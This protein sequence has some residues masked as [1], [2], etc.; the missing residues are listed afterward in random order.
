M[1]WSKRELLLLVLITLVA[2]CLRL[3]KLDE[4]PPGLAG[5]TAYKGIGANRILEGEYPIFFEESW[6]GIEP[7]YMYLL[8]GLFR[9]MGSTPLAIKLLSALIGIA[10]ISL[11]HLLVRDLLNSRATGLLASAF[12]AL[13]FWHVSYSRLGWEIILG[14]PFV[15]LTLYLLWRAL[16]TCRWRD[17]VWAGLTLG[18]SLYTYQ[19]QRFLPI[20]IVGFLLYRGLLEKDFWREYGAKVALSL[21]LALLVVVPLGWYFAMHPD[22]FLGRAGEV[23]IFNPE[24]NPRGPLYSLAASALKVLGTY[25]VRGDPLWRHNLPGRPAFDI[26]TSIFFLVGLAVSLTRWRERPYSLLLLWL[27]ILTFPPILTPPQDVPHF[28]RSI[29]ALPAACILAAIGLT[30]TWSWSRNRWP[31]AGARAAASACLVGVL[32]VG[33]TLTA[34]DYFVVWASYPEL[35]DHYFDGQF[36]DLAEAMNELDQTDG[37]WILPINALASPHDEPGHHTVEFLYRGGAPFH[38]LRLDEYSVANELTRLTSG[39]DR[40][41]LVDYKNYVL[42]EAYNYI[43]ADPKRLLPFVLSKYSSEARR[44]EFESFDIRVYPVSANTSFAVAD[45]W[46]ATSADFGA[47]IQLT[48]VSSGPTGKGEGQAE[49]LPSGDEAWVALRW[50]TLT[51]PT[52]DYKIA[53]FLL[54]QRG[55]TVG[56]V[57]KP[58]LSNHLRPTSQWEPGQEEMDYYLLPSLPATPPGVYDLQIVVYDPTTMRRL[59]AHSDDG[60]AVEDSFAAMELLI[61]RAASPPFM[62]PM[63]EVPGGELTDDLSLLGYDLHQQTVN[64]GERIEVALYWE[65]LQDI[66]QDYFVELEIGDVSGHSWA[67]ERSQPAYGTYPT[68]LWKR[69]EVV[70][71]WHEL[72]LPADTPAGQYSL[73]LVLD[74][75]GE[76]LGEVQLGTILVSGKFRSYEIPPM[77][78]ELGW[79][80]GSEVELLGY[81]LEPHAKAGAALQVTLYWRCLSEMSD[82]YTVFAHVLDS[83]NRIRGQVDRVPGVPEAPTTS[84]VQ[85]EVIADTYEIPLGADVPPGEYAVE[86]GMYDA[87]TMARRPV[88]NA[89]GEQHGDSILLATVKVEG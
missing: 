47:Q 14:P 48:G 40:V 36:V 17:F 73:H 81:D 70:R 88:S 43:D 84:W 49:S 55:R 7:M 61:E 72:R 28:S 50:R 23:S 89:R 56:Q 82:S 34:R 44:H 54:D 30:T 9:L 5:D 80:V 58:L 66:G 71:D 39:R 37:A 42:E 52:A 21:C 79:R 3:Y 10:T 62:H 87:T 2:A 20:L 69:G 16:K 75:E 60:G 57:D 22:A 12:L 59:M 25:N 35:R 32:A 68:R 83:S 74:A 63:Y 18:A 1:P 41:M 26:L 29:G 24:K 85:G 27:I 65:A 19:A 78:Q 76:D 45:S 77:Q 11:L 31:W 51:Q 4:L 15:L 86:V 33:A 6:G 46:R 8:A 53:V 13:S 38:F 67:R 64:P